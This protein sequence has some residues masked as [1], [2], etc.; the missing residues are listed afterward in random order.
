MEIRAGTSGYSYKE[1]RGSF[2]PARIAPSE[3]LAYTLAPS[4]VEIN[5]TFYRMPGA[6][7]WRAGRTR[8]RDVR[9]AVR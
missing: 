1:W 5:N 4:A 6:R 8:Y 3:M 7:W 9:F 2:Y